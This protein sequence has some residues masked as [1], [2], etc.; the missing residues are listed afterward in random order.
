[1]YMIKY[2]RELFYVILYRFWNIRDYY[3]NLKLYFGCLKKD[4]QN[5]EINGVNYNI[6]MYMI[7]YLR[8][9]FYIGFKILEI[10]VDI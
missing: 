6:L 3:R 7:K 8:E 9:L 4:S 2:L 1:M 5:Y 10:I